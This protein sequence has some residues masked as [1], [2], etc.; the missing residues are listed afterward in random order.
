MCLSSVGWDGPGLGDTQLTYHIGEAPASLDQA[1]LEATLE[2]ALD[3][4]SDIDAA[5]SLYAAAPQPSVVVNERDGGTSNDRTTTQLPTTPDDVE[6]RPSDEG[7]AADEPDD[8]S[9]DR[10]ARNSWLFRFGRPSRF[11]LLWFVPRSDSGQTNDGVSVT[12]SWEFYA[13]RPFGGFSM[14]RWFRG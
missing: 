9:P 3:V 13:W 6:D 7:D 1:E 2:E 14:P 8:R 5:L 10:P 12:F 4:W 11:R